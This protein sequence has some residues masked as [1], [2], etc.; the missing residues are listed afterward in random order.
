MSYYRSNIY[1]NNKPIRYNDLNTVSDYNRPT[2]QTCNQRYGNFSNTARSSNIQSS[3]Y[4]Q[5]LPPTRTVVE[6]PQIVYAANRN[7]TLNERISVDNGGYRNAFREMSQRDHYNSSYSNRREQVQTPFQQNYNDEDAPQEKSYLNKFQKP[8]QRPSQPSR[9]RNSGFKFHTRTV[10]IKENQPQTY[11]NYTQAQKAEESSRRGVRRQQELF[12]RNDPNTSVKR[13]TTAELR[14]QDTDLKKA[15]DVGIRN[16]GNSCYVNSVIQ[17]LRHCPSLTDLITKEKILNAM[18]ATRGSQEDYKITTLL[19]NSM[20]NL[21]LG[22]GEYAISNINEIRKHLSK[23]F[24]KF[25]L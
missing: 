1:Q 10:P 8:S 16:T 18:K 20:N 9:N 12:K 13:D 2:Y 24:L 4:A 6:R 22:N 7:R 11:N 17:L 19:N 21:N 25:N 5:E 3:R 14:S 15:K 23:H